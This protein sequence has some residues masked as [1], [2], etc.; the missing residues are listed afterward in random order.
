MIKRILYL[1]T[2]LSITF[3]GVQQKKEYH[4]FLNRFIIIQH[5]LSHTGNQYSRKIIQQ[6]SDTTNKILC[7]FLFIY[8]SDVDILFFHS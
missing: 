5:N 6:K 4:S 3:L 1:K 8:L 2:P 7:T